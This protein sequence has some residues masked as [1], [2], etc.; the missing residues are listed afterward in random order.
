MVIDQQPAVEALTWMQESVHKYRVAPTPEEQADAQLSAF[1]NGRIAIVFGVRGSL[2][3]FRSINSFTFDAAPL[4]K[5]PKG[6]VA[7][8]GLGMTSISRTCK[9]PDQAFTVLNFICSPEGQYLK[10]S[11]GYAHP[12]R[13][14]LVEE[15]WYKEFKTERSYSNRINTIFPDTLKRGEG[16][17]I[18]PHPREADVT[19]AIDPNLQALMRWSCPESSLFV[20]APHGPLP[21]MAEAMPLT[22][23]GREHTPRPRRR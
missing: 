2:G 16:R 13:K 3:T 18:T 17:A 1:P 7:R 21:A 9:I 10:I 20:A 22:V 15:A 8:L 4:P 5:G 14:S 19:S 6:R 23:S 11:H 12:S